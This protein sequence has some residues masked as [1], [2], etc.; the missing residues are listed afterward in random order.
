MAAALLEGPEEAG[1]VPL[2][3]L[4]QTHDFPLGTY[5]LRTLRLKDLR[6]LGLLIPGPWGK[7]KAIRSI[8]R[9]FPQRRFIL[10]GDSGQKDPELYGGVARKHDGQVSRIFIR[11]L[12][13]RWLHPD[14]VRRAF[15]GVRR[16][17]W[18]VFRDSDEVS[19][20]LRGIDQL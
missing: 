14:R 9:A 15:R 13:G 19:R 18:R 2:A 20:N 4:C 17:V 10:V 11:S 1:G 8:L 16:D 7:R 3:E 6:V 5:H 12:D